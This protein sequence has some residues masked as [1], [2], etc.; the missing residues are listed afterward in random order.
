MYKNK[1]ILAIIPARGGSKGIPK[2]NI[3]PLLGKPLIGWT[4]DQAKHSKYIDHVFVSTDNKEIADVSEQFGVK[5]DSFR[6]DELAQDSSTSMD[7]ILYTIRFLEERNLNF[8]LVMM[9]EPTSPLRESSDLDASIEILLENSD[10]E[11]IVGVCRVEGGHPAFLV[12]LENTF[13]RSYLGNNFKVLRRQDID[14]L[15]FFEGSLY[16][17]Y[18]HSLKTRKNFYHEKTIGYIVPK[19]KSFEVDDNIDFMIIEKLLEEKLNSNI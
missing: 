17:S 3:R 15:Y 4:I 13:L 11:S 7:V 1:R 18:V 19:W 10:A 2:K 12:K 6:P 14:D 5:V 9:L 16:L 8:D